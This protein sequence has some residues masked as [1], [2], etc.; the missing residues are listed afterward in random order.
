[1][2]TDTDRCGCLFKQRRV[3]TQVKS[4]LFEVAWQ[5]VY[6]ESDHLDSSRLTK[7]S[8]SMFLVTVAK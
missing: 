6:V 5:N 8:L 3:L 2:S 1:M 7:P 4:L